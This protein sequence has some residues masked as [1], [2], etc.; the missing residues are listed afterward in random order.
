MLPSPSAPIDTT[1]DE[2]VEASSFLPQ[3]LQFLVVVA[4]GLIF[5]AIL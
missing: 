4:V 5:S 3:S 2:F 1:V